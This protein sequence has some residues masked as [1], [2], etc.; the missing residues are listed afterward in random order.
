MDIL[1]VPFTRE[2]ALRIISKPNF[3]SEVVFADGYEL[4]DGYP[5]LDTSTVEQF[6][7]IQ[8]ST[9][10]QSGWEIYVPS[11]GLWTDSFEWET[12]W[13]E[14]GGQRHQVCE[15]LLETPVNDCGMRQAA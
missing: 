13:P 8:A 15:V 6:F 1:G 2:E 14:S 4:A 7:D 5:L 9:P 10:P 11:C 12:V 3:W